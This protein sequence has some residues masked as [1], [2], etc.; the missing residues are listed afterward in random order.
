[1]AVKHRRTEQQETIVAALRGT[2]T[3]LTAQQLHE[4]LTSDGNR[5]GMATVYRTLNRLVADGAADVDVD[6][7]GQQLFR[8][9]QTR[10]HHHHL[11]CRRCGATEEIVAPEIE[12]WAQ[13][14]SAEHGY[15]RIDHHVTV[16]GFCAS[17]SAIVEDEERETARS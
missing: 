16:L 15:T 4:R 7:Q 6:D 12:R 2:D 3:F 14:I 1:M 8:S 10:G 5:I 13:R 11:I 17:C 9:C